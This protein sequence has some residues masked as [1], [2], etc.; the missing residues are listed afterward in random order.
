[1]CVLDSGRLLW[2]NGFWWGGDLSFG[3]RLLGFQ[4]EVEVSLFL[5]AFVTWKAEVH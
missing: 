3:I 4:V 1:M 5:V 2:G